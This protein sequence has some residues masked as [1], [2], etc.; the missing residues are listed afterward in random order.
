MPNCCMY[1]VLLGA[2]NVSTL[3]SSVNSAISLF[4]QKQATFHIHLA[5]F[6]FLLFLVLFCN[7]C[8]VPLQ[9]L[10]LLTLICVSVLRSVAFFVHQR[11]ACCRQL[12][13][14]LRL[15]LLSIGIVATFLLNFA[16]VK[17]FPLATL[18][19]HFLLSH[20]CSLQCCTG[21]MSCCVMCLLLWPAIVRSC[22]K[23]HGSLSRQQSAQH[24]SA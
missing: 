22:N 9:L 14:S 2:Q 11:V 15:T 21:C 24:S 10:A 16:H 12:S 4:A 17:L 18:Y 13:H 1:C 7:S 8:L 20:D 19:I 6:I 23:Q 3:V 5:I